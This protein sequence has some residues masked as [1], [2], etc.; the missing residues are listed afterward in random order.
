MRHVKMKSIDA[1]PEGTRFPGHTYK[2]PKFEA[3]ALVTAGF[4]EYA[5]KGPEEALQSAPTET[6]AVAPVETAA[7]SA[8]P[9]RGRKQ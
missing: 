2:V 7:V 1:G 9:V 5:D 8:K 4:A 6:A 3:H